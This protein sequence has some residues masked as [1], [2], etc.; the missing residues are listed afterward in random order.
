MYDPFPKFQ[1]KVQPRIQ[2]KATIPSYIGED[3]QIGNWLFY[4]GAGGILYDFS[5]RENHGTISGA[6]WRDGLYGWGLSF[7]GANDYV[8]CGDPGTFGNEDWTFLMW[9]QLRDA[10]Q[11]QG[12]AGW[13]DGD[14]DWWWYFVLHDYTGD[15]NYDDFRHSYD[16]NA[17]KVD[18][19]IEGP[20]WVDGGNHLLAVVHTEGS[21]YDLYVDDL[22]VVSSVSDNGSLREDGVNSLH[23]GHSPAGDYY[24]AS[25]IFQALLYAK[26]LSA[27]EISA[28]Y[29]E[30]KPLTD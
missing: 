16:D 19:I 26:A 12:L 30:T 11:A 7:D 8:D 29:N 17:S 23:L 13:G 10:G 15:G 9:V 28:F 27:A 24:L 18:E 4:N 5:G 6:K 14:A 21:G 3:G 20:G 25:N 1:P 2:P 22:G